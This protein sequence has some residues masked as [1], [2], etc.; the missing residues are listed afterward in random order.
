MVDAQ[1]MTLY[2]KKQLRAGDRICQNERGTGTVLETYPDGG[3]KVSYDSSSLEGGSK[4]P[5][6]TVVRAGSDPNMVKV[7]QYTLFPCLLDCC[8]VHPSSAGVVDGH[9]ADEDHDIA[10]M[11]QGMNEVT[12]SHC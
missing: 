11:A 6:V 4:E 5:Q 7:K 10:D 8:W 9:A 3:I 1:L 2:N 12:S